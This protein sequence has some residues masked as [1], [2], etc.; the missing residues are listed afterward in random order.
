[1]ISQ[2]T[3]CRQDSYAYKCAVWEDTGELDL[4]EAEKEDGL[5]P[6]WFGLKEALEKMKEIQPTTEL[7]KDIQ[8]RDSFLL[9]EYIKTN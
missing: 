1:M 7:G 8:K 9:E 6:H 4:T 5:T 3:P 2:L